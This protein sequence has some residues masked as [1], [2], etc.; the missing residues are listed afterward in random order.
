MD[1]PSTSCLAVKPLLLLA[2]FGVEPSLSPRCSGPYTSHNAPLP[3]NGCLTAFSRAMHSFF[4]NSR[5][6]WLPPFL[7]EEVEVLEVE[8]LRN[9]AGGCT[10]TGATY[11]RSRDALR[12][13][14]SGP[15][16]I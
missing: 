13:P 15:R 2:V 8:I 3:H 6:G 12:D 14:V 5:R 9:S 4:C 16:G 11:S 10:L 1:H 7:D